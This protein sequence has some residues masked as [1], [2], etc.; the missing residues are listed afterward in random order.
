V[1]LSSDK[2][3]ANFFVNVSVLNVAANHGC[4]DKNVNPI[5]LISAIIFF[6]VHNFLIYK[7]KNKFKDTCNPI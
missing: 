7:L 4:A 3:G 2:V 5:I 6:M 1:R